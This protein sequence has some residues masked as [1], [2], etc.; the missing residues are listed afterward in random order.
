MTQGPPSYY[1]PCLLGLFA[2]VVIPM[3]IRSLKPPKPIDPWSKI[4][5]PNREIRLQVERKT[6]EHQMQEM[7]DR[8]EE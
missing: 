3:T 7:D 1:Y 6:M 4:P 2:M 5:D 8:W